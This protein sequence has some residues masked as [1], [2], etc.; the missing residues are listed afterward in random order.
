MSNM[1]ASIIK[2]EKVSDFFI[3]LDK[4]ISADKNSILSNNILYKISIYQNS[5]KFLI[6]IK[7]NNKSSENIN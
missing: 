5:Y 6:K 3:F 4:I 7:I 2:Y 1:R